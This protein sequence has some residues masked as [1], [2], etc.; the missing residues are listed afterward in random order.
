MTV[1][2]L[3]EFAAE[4]A[5]K[6]KNVFG[7]GVYVDENTYQTASVEF[8]RIL[9]TNYARSRLKTCRKRPQAFFD[10]RS[11]GSEEPGLLL[12]SRPQS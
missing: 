9:R 6:V 5:K 11:P 10:K 8:V 3:A 1:T 2:G 12:Y 7:R 4:A